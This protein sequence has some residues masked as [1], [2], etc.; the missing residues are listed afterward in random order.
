[1]GVPQLLFSA[2]KTCMHETFTVLRSDGWG[3]RQFALLTCNVFGTLARAEG[4][5][6]GGRQQEK[7]HV[8]FASGCK[9]VTIRKPAEQV[10]IRFQRKEL[11]LS[12][13]GAVGAVLLRWCE[14]S[15]RRQL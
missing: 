15:S 2:E 9:G 12:R 11:S 10:C 7:G 14:F 6:E 3:H 5:M 4:L 8:A 13:E 1:M